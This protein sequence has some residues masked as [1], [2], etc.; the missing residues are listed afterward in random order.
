MPMIRVARA[1]A[2]GMRDEPAL[3]PR[4]FKAAEYDTPLPGQAP[5]AGKTG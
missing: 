2:D 5:R 3:G 1:G 4:G